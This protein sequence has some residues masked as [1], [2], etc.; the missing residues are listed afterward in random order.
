MEK[1]DFIFL[2]RNR[3][4][5]ADEGLVVA[6]IDAPSDHNGGMEGFRSSTNHALDV[7]AVI[8]ELRKEFGIPVWLVGTSRGTISA[9]NAAAR[10]KEHGPNGLV[11]TSSV[12]AGHKGS[13]YDVPLDKIKVPTLIIHH[14]SDGCPA[15][16]FA[17]G[18]RLQKF[19]SHAPV[20]EF[21]AL[22]GGE[23]GGDVC[24]G[25][26][27]HGFQGLDETVVRYITSWIKAHSQNTSSQQSR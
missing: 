8:G 20:V 6:V 16:P 9:A 3:N 21:K 27:F 5:F 2:V 12:T 25:A 7:A 11:L 23:G 26:S 4:R 18:L 19:L 15:S 24:Q 10:I 14:K 1:W 17:G 13:V 22:D